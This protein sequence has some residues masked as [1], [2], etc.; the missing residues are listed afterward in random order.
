MIVLICLTVLVI[1][2]PALHLINQKYVQKIALFIGGA[3][4]VLLAL[5]GKI[6]M[7]ISSFLSSSIQHVFEFSYSIII[8]KI[9][10]LFH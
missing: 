10:C 5:S 9:F 7:Q 2:I 3:L 1:S 4:L 8:Q 6:D